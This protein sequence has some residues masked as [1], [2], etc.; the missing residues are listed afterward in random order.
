MEY[1][2][3]TLEAAVLALSR[4]PGVGPKSALRMALFLLRLPEEEVRTIGQA[5]LNLKSNIRFCSR[6][7]NICENELCNICA[8][9]RRNQRLICVVEDIRDVLALEKTSQYTGTYHVLGG[10]INP[11]MGQGPEDLNIRSLLARIRENPPE[12]V[13]LALN[14]QLEGETT[15]FYIARQILEFTPGTR[16]TNLARG[17]PRNTDIELADEMT[18]ARSLT[19]RTPYQANP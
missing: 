18:L 13:I 5:V 14:A 10:L 8:S 15:M 17:L 12:E 3:R 19:D 9:P 7:Y 4:L 1:P 11:L 6:C 16:V 2:S